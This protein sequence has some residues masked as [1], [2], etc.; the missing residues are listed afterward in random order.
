[1]EEIFGWLEPRTVLGVGT[2]ISFVT[3]LLLVGQ[4]FALRKYRG[5]VLALAISMFF[6]SCGMFATIHIQDNQALKYTST[7]LTLGLAAYLAAMSCAALLYQPTGLGTRIFAVVVVSFAGHLIWPDGLRARNW[8]I[9]CLFFVTL[10]TAIIVAKAR[11]PM[12]PKI[13]WFVLALCSLSLLTILPRFL[14]IFDPVALNNGNFLLRAL[15]WAVLPVL[16]YACLMALINARLSYRLQEFADKDALT[17]AHT[18]RYLLENGTLLFERR[19]AESIGNAHPVVLMIDIDHF[20]RIN[21]TWGHA[22]GDVVLKHCVDT[23]RSV[24][25][26]DDAIVSRYGGEEFC[27][28]IPSLTATDKLALAERVRT[29]LSNSPCTFSGKQISI[30]VSVGIAQYPEASSLE[31]LINRADERLYRAKNSGRDKVVHE[32]YGML[33]V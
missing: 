32:G 1:M 24:V 27:V 10:A 18:R 28:L 7:V 8:N 23:I 17:N 26:R 20:K 31:E 29:Q 2:L 12:A 6:A 5:P 30:T 16:S 33:P 15:V 19:S 14:S 25:R 9:F 11:D 3:A 4:A 22:A 13:R 21:D